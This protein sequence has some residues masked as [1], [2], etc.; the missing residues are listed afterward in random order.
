VVTGFFGIFGAIN[1]KGVGVYDST[2]ETTTLQTLVRAAGGLSDDALGTAVIVRQQ[3]PCMQ[4]HYSE[5]GDDLLQSGDVI[6]FHRNP[7]I[8]GGFLQRGPAGIVRSEEMP[9]EI[10]VAFLGLPLNRPVIVRLSAEFA[11]IADVVSAMKQAPEVAHSVR[12]L[13]AGQLHASLAASGASGRLSEGDLLVFDPSRLSRA[14]LAEAPEFPPTRTLAPAAPLASA[15]EGVSGSVDAAVPTESHVP[16]SHLPLPLSPLPAED[17]AATSALNHDPVNE[18]ASTANEAP[19]P[20]LPLPPSY[21][22][23]VPAPAADTRDLESDGILRTAGSDTSAAEP[24]PTPIE[25]SPSAM[26][27]G[28]AAQS[29][30]ADVVRV[31]ASGM[32]FPEMAAAG[33]APMT[34][35]PS[36]MSASV[37]GESERKLLAAADQ[38][39]AADLKSSDSAATSPMNTAT[40]VLGVLLLAG[41]CLGVSVLWTRIDRSAQ[42]LQQDLPRRG[43]E[44]S[45]RPPLERLIENSIPLVEE[46]VQPPDRLDYHG[47]ERGRRRLMIDQPQPLAGPHFAGLAGK[48]RAA[49]AE[50]VALALEPGQVSLGNAAVEA[51]LERAVRHSRLRRENGHLHAPASNPPTPHPE[52]VTTPSA[53]TTRSLL[54]RVL[55]AMERERRR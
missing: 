7:S 54:D 29:P 15:A 37:P 40:I 36:E 41:V 31:S 3:R 18:P 55:L 27:D 8:A 20:A 9:T 43:L 33:P 28:Q 6:F 4:V 26:S 11:T 22:P 38:A 25:N 35:L 12:V 44:P 21:A 46:Q 10:P 2:T 13:R 32:S 48:Q 19:Y 16:A 50:R 14:S 53:G 47:P 52:A 17:A 49:E 45:E 34:P 42:S 30:R 39:R 23:T 5:S 51:R 24:E 1:Q